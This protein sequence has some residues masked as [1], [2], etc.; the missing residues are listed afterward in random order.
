MPHPPLVISQSLIAGMERH[1]AEAYPAECCGILIGVDSADARRIDAVEPAAN[2]FVAEDGPAGDSPP[3]DA[4]ADIGPAGNGAAGIDAAG[5][6][7]TRDRATPRDAV[8]APGPGKESQ[9]NRF[10][11]TP[12]ALLAAERAASAMGKVV[13]GFYHSHPD[14]PA[15]PSDFDRRHAWDFYSYLILAT[16]GTQVV[17]ATCWRLDESTR[18][19]ARQDIIETP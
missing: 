18:T 8:A 6:E 12:R 2:G 19:F 7:P 14:H 5:K 17:D 4:P 1:A 13:V 9:R 16:Q 10:V 15:R 11:I 3:D